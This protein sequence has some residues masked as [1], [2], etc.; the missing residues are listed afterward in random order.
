MLT[1][2]DVWLLYGA[3]SNDFDEA[4]GYAKEAGQVLD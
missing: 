1:Y 2:A 3:G 4:R